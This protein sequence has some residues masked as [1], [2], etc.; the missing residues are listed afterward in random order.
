[1]KSSLLPVSLSHTVISNTPPVSSYRCRSNCS[2]HCG[3]RVF[4]TVCT[5][6]RIMG[7]V[8]LFWMST[9]YTSKQELSRDGGVSVG[10]PCSC[11][12]GVPVWTWRTG[13]SDRWGPWESGSGL[14][15]ARCWRSPSRAETSYA[16]LRDASTA[17]AGPHTQI[18]T[19]NIMCHVSG[20]RRTACRPV[21][22]QVNLIWMVMIW[23]DFTSSH[24]E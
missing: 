3:L 22:S 10:V 16:A 23:P 20:K 15:S 2:L 4:G 1:M 9:S 6:T 21:S 14:R 7:N 18:Q 13:R 8:L 24:L 17:A 11:T 12:S 5:Q 19:M